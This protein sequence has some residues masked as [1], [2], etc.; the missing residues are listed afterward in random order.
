M[1]DPSETIRGVVESV[2]YP[3]VNNANIGSVTQYCTIRVRG[4]RAADITSEFTNVLGIGTL[5]VVR[6]G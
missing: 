6:L 4:V 5:G 2:A 1:Y 3:V